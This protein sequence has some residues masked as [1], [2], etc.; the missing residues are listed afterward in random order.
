ETPRMCDSGRAN[1]P[2]YPAR[3][4]LL[5]RECT[6]P[7]FCE[8]RKPPLVHGICASSMDEKIMR[9]PDNARVVCSFLLAH[10]LIIP[11]S[12]YGGRCFIMEN[13]ESQGEILRSRGY[14]LVLSRYFAPFRTKRHFLR[15][16]HRVG[17]ASLASAMY[18]MIG[19]LFKKSFLFTGDPCD[20]SSNEAEHLLHLLYERRCFRNVY[21]VIKTNHSCSFFFFFFLESRVCPMYRYATDSVRN[22]LHAATTRARNELYAQQRQ[23]QQQQRQ[24]ESDFGR[25]TAGR[26]R[27]KVYIRYITV[28]VA[29]LHSSAKAATRERKIHIWSKL[30][31][32]DICYK[33]FGEKTTLKSHL[34]TLV[35]VRTRCYA[36]H[37]RARS[38]S[39]SSNN[40]DEAVAIVQVA[41]D[42]LCKRVPFVS[43]R[44]SLRTER[45]GSARDITVQISSSV[46]QPKDLVCP[47][48]RKK[49]PSPF[50]ADA[51]SRGYRRPSRPKQAH[52]GSYMER[53]QRV[54]EHPRTLHMRAELL[55]IITCYIIL[56]IIYMYANDAVS[57]YAIV[58]QAAAT[59]AAVIMPF[60]NEPADKRYKC[61]MCIL[62]KMSRRRDIFIR[63]VIARPRAP[64][65]RGKSFFEQWQQWQQR[66]RNYASMY[67][68]YC[69]ASAAAYTCYMLGVECSWLPRYHTLAPS[70]NSLRDAM[71]T[72][73]TLYTY[74]AGAI[75]ACSSA[76]L[77][78]C[79]RTAIYICDYNTYCRQAVFAIKLKDNTTWRYSLLLIHVLRVCMCINHWENQE[80]V[81]RLLLTFDP[82][83]RTKQR[84]TEDMPKPTCCGVFSVAFLYTYSH[85]AKNIAE[86]ID[87]EIKMPRLAN[88][89]K[90][91]SNYPCDSAEDYYRKAIFIPL[92]DNVIEDLKIT[93]IHH[94]CILQCLARDRL[95]EMKFAPCARQRAE[96]RISAFIYTCKI[97]A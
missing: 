18:N 30:F 95:R 50:L 25:Y 66:V 4:V 19:R 77:L 85:E 22:Y 63:L 32:C 31:E 57:F 71:Y 34:M 24:Q 61:I 78:I 10:R 48:E 74:T 53:E 20:T 73:D 79:Y 11:L 92:L 2:S 67:S 68:L 59:A 40:D 38:S 16:R 89:Q 35:Y 52:S 33:S 12:D 44:C 5:G 55:S 93:H 88:I 62:C 6:F 13:Y 8:H 7:R 60:V 86:E 47:R 76:A 90:N 56:Y 96:A 80:A 43:R 82:G 81:S 23:K 49:G 75:C 21:D 39:N 14:F 58:A 28:S 51:E 94:E 91:R 42:I 64:V 1:L 37:K 15:I 65:S 26:E 72:R 41:K 97:D 17:R 84:E 3:T 29:T 70:A 54:N 46:Q 45:Y 83:S 36:C 9:V 87:A 27:I 69:S